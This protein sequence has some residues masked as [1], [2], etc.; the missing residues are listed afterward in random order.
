MMYGDKS[1][2]ELHVIESR[3][4]SIKELFLTAEKRKQS[5]IT[6]YQA[7]ADIMKQDATSKYILYCQYGQI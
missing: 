7:H 2:E 3:L 6:K 4:Q 1:I 5:K